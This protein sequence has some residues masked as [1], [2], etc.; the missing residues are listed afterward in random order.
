M[1]NTLVK[2][3]GA[4]GLTLVLFTLSASA[5]VNMFL[6]INGIPGESTVTGHAGQVDVLA[7]SWGMS[8]PG[9][10]HGAAGT[11]SAKANFQDLSVTKYVDKS[12]PLLMLHS[13]N[14]ALISTVTL[15]VESAN[16]GANPV[17]IIKIVMSNVLVTSVS[18]GGSGGEDRLT[19]NITLNFSKI[20]Y[21]YSPVNPAGGV[22]TPISFAWDIQ[23]NVA[24]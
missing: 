19:E 4:L 7:W 20:E 21:D 22:V 6:D 13:A 24:Q 12:S 3:A 23:N 5:A 16:G 1:K 14:G 11:G 15:Y 17:Q 2:L 10:T 8:N 9:T 18:S